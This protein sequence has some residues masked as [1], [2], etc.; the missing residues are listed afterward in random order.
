MTSD[1]PPTGGSQPPLEPSSSRPFGPAASSPADSGST[2]SGS[3]QFGPARGQSSGGHSTDD[4]FH[5]IRSAGAVRP[6]DSRWF[7]GVATGLARRWD[8]DPIFVRGIFVALAF[9]GGIG[10]VFY[11]L[12]WLL[13]PQ[14]DGR[15]HLQEA[16]RGHFSAG[17]VGALLLSL[18]MLGGGSGPWDGGWFGWGFPGSLI[19]TAVVVF[20]IW[21]AAKQSSNSVPAAPTSAPT[22]PT[23]GSTSPTYGSTGPTYA[24]TGPTYGS[25][26]PAPTSWPVAE[27]QASEAIS[28]AEERSRIAKA[29]R[30]RSKP[31]KMIVRLT[32]GIALLTAAAILVIGNANDWS[33]PVGLIAAASALAV[34]AAGVIASGL[35]GRRAAGLAGIGLLL[36]IGTL[37]GVGAENAGVRSGQHIRVI[38][39][40]TWNPRTPADAEDQFNLG[41]GEATLWLTDPAILRTATTADPLRVQARVGVGHLTVIVPD[42]VTTQIDMSIG[43]GDVSYPDGSTYRFDQARNGMH[44]AHEQRLTTGPA[45]QPRMI[46][47][48]NQGAGPLDIRTASGMS[49][50]PIPEPS[51]TSSAVPS[52]AVPSPAVPSPSAAIPSGTPT[53]TAT[54]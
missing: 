3:T 32:L 51:A 54:N 19:L 6:D 35:S 1:L 31:S 26:S 33:K 47:D 29:R 52:P 43:A 25:T 27:K 15:I 21:W 40:Q 13:L 4:F 23:Y 18:T 8:L 16:M 28:A 44:D 49:I 53:A 14:E 38:G 41:V 34:I 11:G 9:F 50:T 37:A 24:P 20:G 5:R 48:V 2:H 17:F 30:A 45:G 10:V 46:V 7:A 36:A 12:A 39:E 42:G 22:S